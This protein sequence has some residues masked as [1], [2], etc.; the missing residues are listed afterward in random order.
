[1]VSFQVDLAA[2]VGDILIAAGFI[3]TARSLKFSAEQTKAAN[4]S[5]QVAAFV[6]VLG[7]IGTDEIRSLRSHFLSREVKDI[8]KL[9]ESEK[10]GARRLAVCYDRI[11][12]L[13]RIGM[14]PDVLR[15]F[16]GRDME[17]IWDRVVPVVQD[18]RKTRPT[19][20]T[21]FEHLIVDWRRT[22]PDVLGGSVA[23]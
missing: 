1:M 3:L 16:H 14:D 19:Y 4:S 12:V 2:A 23:E 10:D 9:D 5:R 8:G 20:C 6:E 7:E 15:D 17:Q 21:N 13:A 11:A 22:R 18:V